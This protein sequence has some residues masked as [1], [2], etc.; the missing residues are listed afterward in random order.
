MKKEKRKR[1]VALR[2]LAFFAVCCLA[3]LVV[4]PSSVSAASDETAVI[5]S[6]KS[7]YTDWT[8]D[9]DGVLTVSGTGPIGN[10]NQNTTF[11]PWR[12]YG[13]QI[14]KIV[15]EP[16]V[17]YIGQHAFYDCV[18][19]TEIQ[20][21]SSV[22]G[23]GNYAFGSK[24][25]TEIRI[26]ASVKTM[27]DYVFTFATVKTGFWVDQDN[28]CFSNDAQGVLF[29]KEKTVL[30]KAPTE[31]TGAYT[32]P[33]TVNTIETVAFSFC[34]M[35]TNL[36]IG[37]SVTRINSD[38]FRY[39][40]KLQVLSL[41]DGMTDLGNL[42][43][44]SVGLD[45][46]E[47]L[48]LGAGL[49]SFS[50]NGSYFSTLSALQEINVSSDHPTYCSS[51][52]VMYS[53]DMTELIA[54]P[55]AR[56]GGFQIPESVTCIAGSGFQRC[57]LS[58]IIIPES[59]T[60]IY[61][62]FSDCEYLVEIAIPDKVTEIRQF[63]FR[64]CSELKR[65]QLPAQL[66][67][68]GQ[69]AFENCTS[70]TEI[71]FPKELNKIE[72]GVFEGCSTLSKVTFMGS[73]PSLQINDTAFTGITAV[74]Y[75]PDN[76]LTW[77][78]EVKKDYGGTLTWMAYEVNEFEGEEHTYTLPDTN[79]TLAYQ[80]DEAEKTA[81]IKKC[82]TDA[83]G[84]LEIPEMIDDYTVVAIG[85]SAFQK[86]IGLTSVVVP[87]TVTEIGESAFQ[88]CKGLTSA[89]IPDAITSIKSY[90]FADCGLTSFEFPSKLIEIGPY[91]FQKL[92]MTDV[93][94]PDSVS[95]VG[96]GAFLESSIENV[97]LPD[98]LTYFPNK[99]FKSSYDLK[100]VN[101]PK[102]LVTIGDDVFNSCW[103]LNSAVLP[104]G[105][106][107]IGEAAFMGC[108]A[109]NLY[110]AYYPASSFK[111]VTLP[112]T[113]QRIGKYA[114]RYCQSLKDVTIPDTITKIGEATFQYDYVLESVTLPA[115][116][117]SIGEEAF[118]QCKE[119]SKVTFRW[120]APKFEGKN[121]F[122]QATATCYYPSNNEAWT[123]DLFQDYGGKLTW[124]G[125]EM[126][127][128]E[129]VG[130]GEG[131]NPGGNEGE[132]SGE[133]G[134]SG[135]PIDVKVDN[136]TSS[137]AGDSASITP[138]EKGWTSGTNTFSVSGS[139]PCLVAISRDG[140]ATYER[141]PATQNEDGSYS[142]TAENM[143]ADTS[144]SVLLLGD[145]NGDGKVSNADETKLNAAVLKKTELNAKQM[146]AANVNGDEGVT[147]A[148]LTK[149]HAVILGKTSFSW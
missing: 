18:N 27:G 71:S 69:Y 45:A 143:T 46:L 61:G 39:C 64:G 29:N 115:N 128:P 58:L 44:T 92:K 77:T 125:Q 74:C 72:R 67:T 49:K 17:T 53:K 20:I 7:G 101:Y 147:N 129:G 149:L 148:D 123:S 122:V 91:A 98:S 137:S 126:D 97:T 62:G 22:T 85:P 3:L 107:S 14:L 117:T 63:S 141:L 90:A 105:L 111:S 50:N 109:Y 145:V 130:G 95:I 8:L 138:P 19:A 13:E 38:A 103:G 114:F 79:I 21:G 51:D 136:E 37:D 99:M 6:G 41:G 78:D 134:G 87:D 26:P 48:N 36:T 10:Y 1:L 82:N 102:S 120:G 66:Q 55:T 93:T 33:D 31:L 127:K 140:G 133:T 68:I 116:L 57:A 108:G 83:T 34:D 121:I 25:L 110:G 28:E 32:V 106:I 94:V 89:K 124:V 30:L 135:D 2:R 96:E 73:Y 4:L 142:F 42:F 75:Y 119:L 146:L 65:I 131:G 118:F 80:V 104:E 84:S 54:F 40:R 11:A 16:G 112:S 59:V 24:N 9:S 35:L 52:G 70:L 56:T 12:E 81:M 113:L 132:D 47:T 15:V 76:D 139:Q 43:S 88:G 23:I 5:A 60:E 144:L 86:C 100:N